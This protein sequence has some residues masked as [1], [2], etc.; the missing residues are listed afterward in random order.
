V[1]LT[2]ESDNAWRI[3]PRRHAQAFAQPTI[4][5]GRSTDC[6]LILLGGGMSRLHAT[7][8]IELGNVTILDHNT[9]NGVLIDGQ[10]IRSEV[11]LA[12]G[13][14]ATLGAWTLCVRLPDRS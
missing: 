13:Q 9:T 12:P 5:I 8:Q 1:T 6:D 4:T 14:T 2:V 7:L 10:R 11:V 3:P